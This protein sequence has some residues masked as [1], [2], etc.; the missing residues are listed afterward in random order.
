M[1]RFSYLILILILG[2]CA[3]V[4]NISGG[5][6]DEFAPAPIADKVSPPNETTMFEGKSVTIPFNEFITLQNPTQNIV[7]VPP[8]AK[9]DASVKGKTLTLKWEEELN[10][11]TTYSIYLNGAV[12]DI[13]ESNDSIIQYVFS[14]GPVIDSLSYTGFVMDAI[15]QQPVPNVSFI[16]SDANSD[17]V[18]NFAPSNE[19][20]EVKL[21]YIKEGRYKL[22]AVEDEDRNL[23]VSKGERVA[24]KDNRE[25]N[26]V[27]STI[28]SVPF[29]LFTPN[30][31]ARIRTAQYSAPGKFIVGSTVAIEDGDI[32]FDGAPVSEKNVRWH[33]DDSL[34]FFLP[35][36]E[37]NSYELVVKSEDLN[38]TTNIR[39]SNSGVLT[40]IEIRPKKKELSPVDTLKFYTN[41]KIITIDQSMIS[42]LNSQDSTSIKDFKVFLNKDEFYIDID[43]SEAEGLIVNIDSGA[44][45]CN[46][47]VNQKFNTTITC[48]E[49]RKYGTLEIDLSAYSNPIIFEILSGKTIVGKESIKNPNSLLKLNYLEPKE[50]TFRVI[51]DDNENGKW[52]TGDLD[53]LIQP[54]RMDLYSTPVK[55]RANWEVKVP[56]VPDNE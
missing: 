20:G 16:L 30:E 7:M 23:E 56:L 10:P 9:I 31:K 2:A 55:V 36:L 46:Y 5:N 11:N 40:P 22:V 12:K 52:D 3:Q 29:R 42:V 39:V 26:L 4:G 45:Q 1:A 15:T 53:L 37:A 21:N 28:D 41:D 6:K 48:K 44:V 47:G 43:R 14:T 8:H 34:T 49:E 18:V 51:H 25:I 13:T 33:A 27:N 54:E 24:F 17:D 38:D 50:Y 19:K 32:F 35:N